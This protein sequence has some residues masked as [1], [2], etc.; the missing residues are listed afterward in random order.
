MAADAE[1]VYLAWASRG[2]AQL[3]MPARRANR[4]SCMSTSTNGTTWS[5]PYPIDEPNRFGHQLMPALTFGA[6]KLSLIYYDLREDVSQ[7]FGPFVDELPILNAPSPKP[8]RHTMDVRL[9]QADP[10]P[11]PAFQSTQLSEYTFGVVNGANTAQQLTFNPPNLTLFRQGTVP[12]M[13]DYID[14]ITA[15]SIRANAGW[16]VGLQYRSRQRRRRLCRL[17]RQPQ[18]ACGTGGDLTAYTPPNSP[19]P[20]HGE[21][22]RPQRGAAPVRAGRRPAPAIKTSSAPGSIRGW[23]PAAWAIPRR[24]GRCQRGFALH[25]PEHHRANPLIPARRSWINRLAGRPRSANLSHC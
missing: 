15:P 17:D 25:D 8:P 20:R 23:S 6:G 5:A 19:C 21:H 18:R 22:L 16:H 10:G 13:G 11:A 1:R 14:L 12:F 9:A 24:S 3:S 7:L 4:E 2:Y